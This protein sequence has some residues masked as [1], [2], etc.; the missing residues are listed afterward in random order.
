MEEGRE[1]SIE[2][3][4]NYVHVKTTKINNSQVNVLLVRALSTVFKEKLGEA[5]HCPQDLCRK[6][7]IDCNSF[8]VDDGMLSIDVL[9]KNHKVGC[10]DAVFTE[11]KTYCNCEYFQLEVE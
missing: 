7:V 3:V 4:Q 5:V 6:R 11:Y 9:H 8:F 2:T 10:K 1:D